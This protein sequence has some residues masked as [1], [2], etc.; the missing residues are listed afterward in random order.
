MMRLYCDGGCRPNPGI[1]AFAYKIVTDD[2]EILQSG[3][4]GTNITNNESEFAAIYCGLVDMIEHYEL[5]LYVFSDSQFVTHLLAGVYTT[6]DLRFTYMR[7]IIL[8]MT[9]GNTEFVWKNRRNSHIADCDKLC[10]HVLCG[11]PHLYDEGLV[12]LNKIGYN[13][14][15]EARALLGQSMSEVDPRH[16][17]VG[18]EFDIQTSPLS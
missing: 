14:I 3:Y 15:S 7:E 18:A 2:A 11:M 13:F 8:N 12:K 6:K 17:V 4:L 16:R 10:D 1:S 5:P 9:H